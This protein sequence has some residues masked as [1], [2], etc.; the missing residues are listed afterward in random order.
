MLVAENA[1]LGICFELVS[2]RATSIGDI[3]G[4]ALL[5]HCALDALHIEQEA[6]QIY[7]NRLW[8]QDKIFVP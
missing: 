3:F 2:R 1:F 8:V 7:Q 4:D 5:Y 6:E